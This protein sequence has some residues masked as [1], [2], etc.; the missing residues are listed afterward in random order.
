MPF[1]L[2]N[3]G[4]VLSNLSR[5]YAGRHVDMRPSGECHPILLNVP[6]GDALD[7]VSLGDYYEGE[8]VMD[9]IE[10]ATTHVASAIL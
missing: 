2:S 8:A 1:A 3:F 7:T 10:K 6:L 4:V 5:V 9:R